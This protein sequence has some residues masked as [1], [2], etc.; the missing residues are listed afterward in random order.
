MTS[1][2]KFTDFPNDVDSPKGTLK[3][4]SSVRVERHQG[5]KKI[6][7]TQTLPAKPEGKKPW[8]PASVKILNCENQKLRKEKQKFSAVKHVG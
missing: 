5:A 2:G 7:T 1:F 8:I 4:R 3:V 6:T